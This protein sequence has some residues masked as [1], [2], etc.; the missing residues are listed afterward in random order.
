MKQEMLET[1]ANPL[2]GQVPYGEIDTACYISKEHVALE[3]ER[4]WP[5]TWQVAC[6]EEEIPATGDYVEYKVADQTLIV[7]RNKE[8]IKAFFNS[9]LHR[10]TQLVKGCGNTQQFTC[11]FHG[12]RWSIDGLNRYVHDRAEFPGLT[13]EDLQ[14]PEAQVGT[15]GGFVFVK[16]SEGGASLEEYLPP[17][18]D[19]LAAYRLE[20]YRIRSWR[21]MIVKCNWKAALEAFEE[22]YHTLGTHP[23]IMKGMDDI[24]VEYDTLG[25]H[26][27]MIVTNAVPSSR[28]RGGVAEQEVLEVSIAGLLDF[29]LADA[30]ERAYLEEMAR[31]PL[32]EGQT[33]RDVFR[34]MAYEKNQK[35]MPDLP[36]DQYLQ[37]YHY[38]IFPNICF[39]LMPGMFVGLMARPNGDDPDSCV[40]DMITLQ[41]PGDEARE[42]VKREWIDDPETAELGVVMAQDVGNFERV[43]QGMHNRPLRK[44]KLAGY[45][46]KRLLNRR[47]VIDEFF[48]SYAG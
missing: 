43:Q 22:T 35:F 44:I 36:V 47:R 7:I 8:G 1:V 29:G 10:G 27:R 16:L 37:V 9:C 30:N 28:Y 46:E 26:S 32:P 14:L 11:P 38:T 15:W 24:M 5:H 31:T 33:T 25:M 19:H 48:A 34:G 23:Q 4:L 21:T 20:E 18:P 40:F 41:H 13:R 39:N 45:Q 6:R 3:R 2:W 12:W 17:V 42:P